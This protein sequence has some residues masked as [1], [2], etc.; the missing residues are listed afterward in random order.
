[1]ITDHVVK[2]LVIDDFPEI[3]ILS[4]DGLREL[5]FRTHRAGS[6]PSQLRAPDEVWGVDVRC[7]EQH[8]WEPGW[9]GEGV[10]DQAQD[11]DDA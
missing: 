6:S 8:L 1:L 9:E 5:E 7:T 3:D 11:A 10:T 4:A 2:K